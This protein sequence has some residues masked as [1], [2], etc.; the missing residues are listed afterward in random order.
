MATI[1]EAL[2]LALDLHLAG[3]FGEAQE[4]YTRILDV[5][6]EQPDALHYL[7]VLAGQIDRGE[8]GLTLIGKALALRPEAADIHANRANLLRGLDR[9]DEAEGSYRRAL[10]LRPDFAEAWTDR[11]FARH[12][13][14]DPAAIDATA[15][16]LERAL[17]IE[18]AL[19]PAREKLVDLLHARGRLRL[20]S[21]Q[22]T[23]ALADLIRAAALDQQDADIAFL[24][25]NALFAAGLRAD[26]VIA[27]RNALA[28]V[29]DFLSAALN[30]GIA[31]AATNHAAAALAPLRHAVRIDPAHPAPRD[32]LALA[33]R[34]L[35]RIE[36]ADAL[37]RPAPAPQPV[38]PDPKPAPFRRPRRRS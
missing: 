14:S 5:E 34:S 27:F 8:F 9:L 10:A 25:G 19:D 3:R 35:G 24:L 2:T 32:T 6:P 7:G 37:A 13:R 21:G 20:E 30:L 38:K 31:L 12:G 17:Q 1:L 16:M 28:L 33:L 11:A 36:E 4:L 18:P 26:S 29:P 23:P 22:V 15:T